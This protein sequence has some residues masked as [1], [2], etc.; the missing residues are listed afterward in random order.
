M[1]SPL[2]TDVLV[3]APWARAWRR[4]AA[5]ATLPLLAALVLAGCAVGPNFKRPPAPQTAAYTA[6]RAARPMASEGPR[7]PRRPT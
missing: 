2:K 7:A 5:V 3:A 1:I 6:D 4:R